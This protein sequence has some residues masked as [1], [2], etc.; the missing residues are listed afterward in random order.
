MMLQRA[1]KRRRERVKKKTPL[2]QKEIEA[3]GQIVLLPEEIK[4]LKMLKRYGEWC[5]LDPSVGMTLQHF[6]FIRPAGRGYLYEEP[7]FFGLAVLTDRGMRYCEYIGLRQMT[8]RL[9]SEYWR[10]IFVSAAT[11]VLLHLLRGLLQG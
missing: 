3:F 2:T 11:T 7:S 9:I 5:I 4:T 6:G 8:K 1:T 10:A